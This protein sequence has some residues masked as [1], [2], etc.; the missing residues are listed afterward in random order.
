MC[1][2][3]FASPKD[4]IHFGDAYTIGEDLISQAEL[5]KGAAFTT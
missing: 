4:A 2:N 1:D 5:R 3:L